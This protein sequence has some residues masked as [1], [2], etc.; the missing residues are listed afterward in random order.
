MAIHIRRAQEEDLGTV[1]ALYRRWEAEGITWGLTAE[2]AENLRTKLGP[3]FLVAERGGQIV[4]FV[5]GQ[6][7]QAS[8]APPDNLAVFPGGADYLEVEDLY[9]VE[10]AR[11]AGIGTRLVEGVL[12]AARRQ[13]IERSTVFSATKDTTKITRFYERLGYRP[14]GIQ[15]FK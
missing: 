14:W 11:R 10:H 13:G 12:E 9:V 3:F 5:A 2:S 6:V 1:A 15:F 8:A 4:G 7:H